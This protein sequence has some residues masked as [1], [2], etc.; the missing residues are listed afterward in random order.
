MKRIINPAEAVIPALTLL[1]AAAYLIQTADAPPIAIKWPYIVISAT[2]VLWLG[3]LVGYVFK[4]VV[5]QPGLS[6]SKAGKPILM[7]VAPLC[8]LVS[9]PFLGFSLSCF[10]FLLILFKLL[11]SK[12]WLHAIGTALLI[13]AFLHLALIVFMNM[14]LPRLELGSFVL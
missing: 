11:G 4:P 13:S 12:S 9:M 2:A 10:L 8:F 3:I 6:M 5:S 7:I 14:S 1:F